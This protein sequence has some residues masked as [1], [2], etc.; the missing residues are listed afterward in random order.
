[1]LEYRCLACEDDV[2]AKNMERDIK[3]RYRYKFGS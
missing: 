2:E 3:N 1:M